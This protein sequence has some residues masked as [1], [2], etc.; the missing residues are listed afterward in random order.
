MNILNVLLLCIN[1]LINKDELSPFN[2]L[3]LKISLNERTSRDI[4]LVLILY[5]IL[6]FFNKFIVF[7]NIFI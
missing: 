7:N 3:L 6:N 4:Y 5:L 1:L 2:N